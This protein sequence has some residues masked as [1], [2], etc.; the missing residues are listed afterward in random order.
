MLEIAAATAGEMGTGR[1][2]STGTGLQDLQDLGPSIAELALG[3]SNAD[4]V[5]RGAARHEN[6]D[7]VEAGEAVAA[8]DQF[9]DLQLELFDLAQA[10]AGFDLLR[11][12]L[13]LVLFLALLPGATGLAEGLLVP[14]TVSRALGTIPTVRATLVAVP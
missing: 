2:P 7:T 14:A 12:A 6:G 5:A 8:V 4:F 11:A 13:P 1:F 3:Q 9:F 10:D